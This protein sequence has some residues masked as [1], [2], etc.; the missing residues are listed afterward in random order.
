MF[1]QD[2]GDVIVHHHH[3]V[4][5]PAPL[6]REHPDRGRPAADAH[7]LLGMTVDHRRAVRLHDQSRTVIDGQ[8]HRVAVAEIEQRVAGRPSLFPAAAGQVRDATQR[9]HLRAIF[10]GHHMADRL[11]LGAHQAALRADVPVGVDLHLD[12]A[13]AEDAL[14][15]HGHDIDAL[16][17]GGNDEGC[18]LVVGI[19]GA[20]ADGRDHRRAAHDVAIPIGRAFQERHD[21]AP[22]GHVAVEDDMR[23]DAH[24]PPVMVRIAV[25]G[26]GHPRAD[27][28]QHR[29]GIAADRRVS[30]HRRHSALAG[31]PRC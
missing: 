15:H 25:A 14:R 23:I 17:L 20:G 24:E 16:D 27:V 18:G 11:A 7:P 22:A 9:Q 8:F 29:A 13:I 30:L 1:R 6:P 12:T 5:V 28:A 4:H 2:A 19:C 31:R 21:R 26:A 3:L 10:A